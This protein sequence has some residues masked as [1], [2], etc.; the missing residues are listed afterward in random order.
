MNNDVEYV[1]KNAKR[2]LG[3]GRW[4]KILKREMVALSVADNYDE[5]KYEWKATGE[6]WYVPMRESADT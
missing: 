6:V 4:D 2:T 5:A 1:M 3:E